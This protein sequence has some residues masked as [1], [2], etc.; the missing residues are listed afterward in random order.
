MRIFDKS[1]VE[2]RNNSLP[3]EALG[4]SFSGVEGTE[5]DMADLPNV[6]GN[7][8]NNQRKKN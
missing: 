8:D 7:A 6:Y 5:T 4:V 2:V 1:W 3:P